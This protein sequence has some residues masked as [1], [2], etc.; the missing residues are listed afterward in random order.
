MIMDGIMIETVI[1]RQVADTDKTMV[2]LT[3]PVGTIDTTM[4][5][6]HTIRGDKHILSFFSIVQ[7]SF[8]D[9]NIPTA[10]YK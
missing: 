9:F 2:D 4:T 7:S 5:G 1:T 10:H 6:D 8:P 3:P